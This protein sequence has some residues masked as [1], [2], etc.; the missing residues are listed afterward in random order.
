MSYIFGWCPLCYRANKK[1]TNK[2]Y[3]LDTFLKLQEVLPDTFLVND[4]INNY[5]SEVQKTYNDT[6]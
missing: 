1:A 6:L 5:N 3:L 2:R 4:N